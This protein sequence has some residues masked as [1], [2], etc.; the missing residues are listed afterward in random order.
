MAELD[1]AVE[2]SHLQ[3]ESGG[4]QAKA[5]GLAVAGGHSLLLGFGS[6]QLVVVIEEEGELA[7]ELEIEPLAPGEGI[8]H[9]EAEDG[10]A[11]AADLVLVE[12]L[13]AANLL[14]DGKGGA[15]LGVERDQ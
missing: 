8:G 13:F 10:E 12:G 9:V 14:V 11:V 5:F 2:R 6:A 1:L 15:V 7:V 4:G 3:P